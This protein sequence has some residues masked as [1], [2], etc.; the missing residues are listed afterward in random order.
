V[1]KEAAETR[2]AIISQ[3][4]EKAKSEGARLLAEAKA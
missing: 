3:A 1:L 2:E 4:Q